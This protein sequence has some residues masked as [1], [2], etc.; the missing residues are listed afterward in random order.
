MQETKKWYLRTQDETFGPETEDKLIEWARLGRIQPGQEVSNDNI[1]WQ[2]VEDVP[3]LDMRFSIDIGDGNPRGPFNKVA[4]E[5]LL[6]SGRLPKT[7]S[8]VEV[9]EPF[10]VE[11]EAKSEE[12]EV[13]REEE[14]GSSEEGGAKIEEGSNEEVEEKSEESRDDAT[15]QPVVKE[16]VKEVPVEKIVVKEVVKEVPVE[17]IVEVEKIVVDD[18]RIKELEG[19][20]EEER[21]HTAELQSRFDETSR[22]A[23]EAAKAATGREAEL[24]AQLRSDSERF[25]KLEAALR[26]ATERECKYSEQ[27]CHLEDELRR[28]PQAASEVADIQAAMYA[29]MGSESKELDELIELEK[30]ELEELKRA[31]SARID[32]LTERRRDILKRSGANIEEMTRRALVAKPEDPR[33]IQLRKDLEELE[34]TRE[35]ETLEHESKVRELTE[36]L[37]ARDAEDRRAQ[38]NMKDV[39][40]LRQDVEKLREQLQMREKELMDERQINGELRQQQATRQQTLLARLA[41][42]E[43]PSIGNSQTLSTNQSREAH[44]VKLPG[45]MRFKH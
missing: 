7:A 14:T 27:I 22:N 26:D 15:T 9:R 25:E 30:R 37:K 21:R 28:L 39:V 29:I 38:E 12:I 35:R 36:L 19:L 24:K 33:T 6:A 43:S 34:R 18:T 2:R 41:S 20:L 11:V 1:L 23:A 8:I 45:W 17:K 40:Q 16:I 3:F 5:S 4:A 31:Q 10:E 13:K 42:L 32:R 44:E